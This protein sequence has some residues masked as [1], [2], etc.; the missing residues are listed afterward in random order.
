[1]NPPLIRWKLAMKNLSFLLFICLTTTTFAETKITTY[2]VTTQEERDKNRWTLTEWLRIKERMKMM[3]LWLA[4]M[5]EPEKSRFTPELGIFYGTQKG[6]TQLTG[7]PASQP[8][9][10]LFSTTQYGRM[11]LWLTNLVS[12]T[13]GI[14]TLNIDLGAEGYLSKSTAYADENR[15][16]SLRYTT[17]NLR[18]FGKSIQDSSLILKYGSYKYESPFY[19]MFQRAQSSPFFTGTMTGAEIQLY[20][21]RWIGLEGNYSQFATSKTTPNTAKGML[22]EYGIYMEISLIRLML[23]YYE[24]QWDFA[25]NTENGTGP[26]TQN[27]SGNYTGI[28]ILF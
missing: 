6:L 25:G 13:L 3:D 19:S 9:S 7:A 14:K 24:E 22:L 28:K 8:S 21:F 20:L 12:G 26:I 27:T 10:D 4:L 18:I 1:M 23:G 2:V 17:G 15:H 5:S 11:H 16:P